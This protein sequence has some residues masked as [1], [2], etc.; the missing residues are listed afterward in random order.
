MPS[1]VFSSC[2]FAKTI[3]KL[4][5]CSKRSFM[6]FFDMIDQIEIFSELTM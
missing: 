4:L 6:L 5:L 3:N 1:G 2:F